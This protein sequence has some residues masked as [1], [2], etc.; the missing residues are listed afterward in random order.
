VKLHRL[1]GREVRQSRPASSVLVAACAALLCA[2]PATAEPAIDPAVKAQCAKDLMGLPSVELCESSYELE[3][4]VF[5]VIRARFGASLAR[6]IETDLAG[7]IA[8]QASAGSGVP[9]VGQLR[10]FYLTFYLGYLFQDQDAAQTNPLH[11]ADNP[12]IAALHLATCDIFKLLNA[13][14]DAHVMPSGIG[15]KAKEPT[16]RNVF[17]LDKPARARRGADQ[18][19]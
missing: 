16:A 14:P 11:R 7:I 1:S 13:F 10:T 19:P 12:S 8:D 17:G 3:R 5:A 6:A 18:C 9:H 4:R 2:S 15:P